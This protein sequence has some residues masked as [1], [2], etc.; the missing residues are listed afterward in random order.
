MSLDKAALRAA[1]R[2]RLLEPSARA[3]QSDALRARLCSLDF[4][5]HAKAVALFVGVAHEPDTRALFDALAPKVRLL[6]KVM[7][8]TALGW[9]AVE[10]WESLEQG[11]F[12]ILEPAVATSPTLPSDL[13]VVLVPGLAFD[14]RG[15]RLGWGRGYYDRA[16]A[17]VPGA[18]R[19]GI[20]LE[21]GV[22]EHVPMEAHDLPMHAVV[23]PDGLVAPVGENTQ[24]GLR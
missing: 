15:G 20:C 18:R 2:A 19:V 14:R 6:P 16:L 11:R 5:V 17:Q 23:T 1:Q 24:D 13:D 8:P 21:P 22:V 9:A 12:G 3:R 7:G 10:R 4:I